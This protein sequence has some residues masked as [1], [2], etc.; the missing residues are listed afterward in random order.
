MSA[1]TSTSWAMPN[2]ALPRDPAQQRAVI[3]ELIRSHFPPQSVQQI[4]AVAECEST[5]LLHVRN[6]GE[7]VPNQLGSSARGTLQIL[8]SVH[9]RAAR[10]RGLDI[11]HN[12][13]DYLRYARILYD[14]NRRRRGDGLRPWYPSRACWAPRLERRPVYRTERRDATL[15]V[16]EAR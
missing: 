1:T 6:D 15:E 4:L 14:E 13:H 10:Q 5:G 12:V 2:G 8:M 9:E 11:R 16:A 3:E 7:L